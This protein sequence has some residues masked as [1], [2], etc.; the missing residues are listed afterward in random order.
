MSGVVKNIIFFGRPVAVAC[1]GKCNKAWGM[2]N[3][4]RLK[5]DPDDPN[6]YAYQ[7]DHELGEA[8]EDPGTYEGECAKPRRS[9]DRMN[10]WCVRECER[11]EMHSAGEPTGELTDFD[12]RFYNKPPHYRGNT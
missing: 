9:E 10:K 3:R 1:D 4:P 5:L 7:A 12:R 6:D 11:S 2:N 8:P